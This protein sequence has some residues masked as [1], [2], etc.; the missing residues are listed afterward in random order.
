MKLSELLL[1]DLA[2]NNPLR[3]GVGGLIGGWCFDPGFRCAATYRLAAY[4][5]GRGTFGRVFSKVLWLRLISRFGVHISLDA[6]IG[7]GLRLPH[8]VGI[9][10]GS[11]VHVGDAVTLYQHV[12]LGRGTDA[13][14]AYPR[15][16]DHC[17]IYAGAVVVGG[18]CVGDRSVIGANAVVVCDVPRDSLAVGVPAKIKSKKANGDE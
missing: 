6:I 3:K 5:R 2:A 4:F 10:V 18:V 8:P 1:R 9:V 15:V 12:T 14:E 17:V 7:P 13:F 11:Q 16:G